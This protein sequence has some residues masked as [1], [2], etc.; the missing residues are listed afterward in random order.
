VPTTE[1]NLRSWSETYDWPEGGEEWSKVWG[2]SEAQWSFVIHPRIHLFLPTDTILE[3]APGYGRWTQYLSPQCRRLVGVDLSATCVEACTRRFA[4][5]PH[6][7]FQQ[8]DGYSLAA[9]AD[10]SIDFAF[11]FDSLVHA[12]QDVLAAY[13]REFAVC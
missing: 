3:I 5:V 13:L 11:S 7:S 10:H 6:A 8:N 4:Q 2:G 12:E 9:I 1:E